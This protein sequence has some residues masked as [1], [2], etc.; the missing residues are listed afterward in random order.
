MYSS[1]HTVSVSYA[2][3][4]GT[5]HCTTFKDV[6]IYFLSTFITGLSAQNAEQISIHV[7]DH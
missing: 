7:A 1:T 3:I 6:D 4:N 2:D 5:L